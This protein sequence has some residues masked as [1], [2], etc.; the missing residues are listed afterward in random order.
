MVEQR[1]VVRQQL[2]EASAGLEQI[3]SGH[4]D[5]ARRQP[6]SGPG[7]GLDQPEAARAHIERHCF[8]CGVQPAVG[9][10]GE[11]LH[12]HVQRLP[13]HGRRPE[14][15]TGVHVI[16]VIDVGSGVSGRICAGPT[17]VVGIRVTEDL[18]QAIVEI[19]FTVRHRVLELL[20]AVGLTAQQ[21]G[22][23]VGVIEHFDGV[24]ERLDRPIV[25][26]LEMRLALADGRGIDIERENVLGQTQ[27]VQTAIGVVHLDLNVRE[28]RSNVVQLL[29]R[30]AVYFSDAGVTR[31]GVLCGQDCVGDNPVEQGA[32]S[33][34]AAPF[35]QT[36]GPVRVP[37]AVSLILAFGIFDIE[38][39]VSQIHD[40]G[41]RLRP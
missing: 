4:L 39:A 3:G 1:V 25:D 16:V 22:G 33:R 8:R 17:D 29:D 14:Q 23:V 34:P 37:V 15:G 7:G 12:R 31:I 30:R 41:S 32:L 9:V 28:R 35:R 27:R 2:V 40:L 24:V 19:G 11:L 13:W 21:L 38:T 36:P 20:R 6:L 18:D 10:H 26:L 5:F